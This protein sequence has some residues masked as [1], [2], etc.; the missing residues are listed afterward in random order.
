LDSYSS[1]TAQLLDASWRQVGFG[2]TGIKHG[3]HGQTPGALDSFN[4][5]YAS[6]PRDDW[7]PDLVVINQGS[8][9]KKTPPEQYLPFY[10]QYLSL[11]R[12]AY[13]KAKI[14]ALRPFSG[15]QADSIRQAVDAARAAG[16]TS[17]VYIDTTGWYSGPLHPNASASVPLAA[18]LVAAL[19]SN[20]L[21]P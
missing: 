20:N 7:Q 15:T 12:Q 14:A 6:C 17:I 13:P 1:Q 8:N 11:I 3:G 19:K 18:H 16:D 5:F 10:V 21:V 4:F 9:D 2:A